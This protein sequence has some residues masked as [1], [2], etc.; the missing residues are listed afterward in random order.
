MASLRSTSSSRGGSRFISARTRPTTA[1]ARW[2]SSTTPLS[3][4]RALAVS[5]GVAASQRSA[6]AALATIAPSGWL[7]SWAIEAASCPIVVTRAT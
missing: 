5:G 4:S 6:A 1:P 3:A 7:T 2:P